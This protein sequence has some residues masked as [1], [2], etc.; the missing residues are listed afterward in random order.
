VQEPEREAAECGDFPRP[1]S[2][3]RHRRRHSLQHIGGTAQLPDHLG[4]AGPG[5]P[6]AEQEGMA[7]GFIEAPESG[8]FRSPLVNRLRKTVTTRNTTATATSAAVARRLGH[9]E[10]APADLVRRGNGG[11]G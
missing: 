1:S 10:L 7:V 8:D 2:A 5:R 6:I 3:W 9:D 11:L 4:E